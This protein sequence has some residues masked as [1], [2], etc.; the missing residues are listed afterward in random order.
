MRERDRDVVSELTYMDD[1]QVSPDTKCHTY[2]R[3]GKE[4][5]FVKISL[6]LAAQEKVYFLITLSRKRKQSSI[7]YLPLSNHVGHTD[8]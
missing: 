7:G 2:C 6:N 4:K 5:S 1:Q 3:D 8:F